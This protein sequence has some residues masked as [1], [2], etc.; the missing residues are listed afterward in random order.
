MVK[1]LSTTPAEPTLGEEESPRTDPAPSPH[2]KE[3]LSSSS[4]PPPTKS[5]VRKM[6]ESIEV[7]YE[8]DN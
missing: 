4:A 1:A 5:K 2:A 3:E 8:V 7:V 6:V